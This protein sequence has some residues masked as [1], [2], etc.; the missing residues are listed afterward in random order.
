MVHAVFIQPYSYYTHLFPTHFRLDS[1]FFGVLLSYWHHFHSDRFN[2][3]I[4]K[5]SPFLMPPSLLLI[6]PAVILEQSNFVIYTIGLS[7]LYLGYGCLMIAL[8]Q[9]PLTTKGFT[10]W[11]LK[12]LSYI[13]QHSYPIYLFHILIIQLLGRHNLLD[14]WVGSVAYFV[15]SIT[16]GILI[17]KLI[18]FPVLRLRDRIF[19]ANVSPSPRGFL[20]QYK[21][22]I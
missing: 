8:L 11:L 16:V 21:A 18:E 13:G 1:L 2:A 19:P 9:V 12:P 3:S 15:S 4:K 5:T 10:G 7:S 22:G 14:T 6:L 20:V 17:S